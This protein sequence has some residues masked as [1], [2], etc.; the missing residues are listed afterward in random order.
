MTGICLLLLQ[1]HI[2]VVPVPVV[3]GRHAVFLAEFFNEMALGGKAEEF[4]NLGAAV[5]GIFQHVLRHFQLSLQN[6]TAD[7]NAYLAGEQ[8][9]KIVFVESHVC[10][11]FR[12][13]YPA[14]EMRIYIINA[15]NHRL[16]KDFLL[17]DGF[18]LFRIV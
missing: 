8:S 7:R 14:V 11:H 18:H 1:S 4:G 2:A 17:A 5:I 16:G 15:F 9:G 6:V 10:C 3:Q 13:R 12:H